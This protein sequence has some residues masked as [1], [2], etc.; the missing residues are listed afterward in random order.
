M[1]TMAGNWEDIE[2]CWQQA[3]K[4]VLEQLPLTFEDWEEAKIECVATLNLAA[5]LVIATG[6]TQGVKLFTKKSIIILI[7]FGAKVIIIF[8]HDIKDINNHEI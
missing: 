8:Y 6:T 5:F 1:A 7:L 3:G 4:P 2:F